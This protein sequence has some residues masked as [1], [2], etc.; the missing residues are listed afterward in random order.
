M[1]MGILKTYVP[2]AIRQSQAMQ[3][4]RNMLRAFMTPP[5][6]HLNKVDFDLVHGCQL[7]CVGCPNSTLHTKV[8][9]ISKDDFVTCLRQIDVQHIKLFR[10]F[11]YGEV[12]LHPKLPELVRQLPQQAYTIDRVEI[13]TNAQHHDWPKFEEVLKTGVITN[14]VVSCDGDGTPEEYER[15]R[16]PAKW[17]RLIEFLIKARELRDQCA[18]QI[19]LLTR[20]ICV[21]EEG[22]QRW[23]EVVTPLGWTPSFRGWFPLPEASMDWSVKV[24]K[25][26]CKPM[27]TARK[28]LYVD[29][30][31]AVVPCCFHPRAFVL[32]NLHQQTFRQIMTGMRYKMM[33]LRMEFARRSM[34]VCGKCGVS[35][36]QSIRNF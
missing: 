33:L 30:D 35:G 28:H 14:L 18:P 9:F 27:Y 5:A 19:E 2:E 22:R 4:L 31:G 26:A 21:T 15:L 17:E 13:C 6:A 24:P 32:G 34:V 16:P 1:I 25:G 23:H 8:S 20:N 29:T 7:R 11:N 10:V 12:L 3:R 36:Q